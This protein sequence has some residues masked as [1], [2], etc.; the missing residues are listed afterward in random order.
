[1]YKIWEKL[2]ELG[3]EPDG[4]H[5]DIRVSFADGHALEGRYGHHIVAGDNDPEIE[6]LSMT[7]P[8]EHG[9]Y[10]IGADEDITNIELI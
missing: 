2:V 6:S 4:G 10:D 1:M 9:Y 7:V 5:P 3:I 8:G